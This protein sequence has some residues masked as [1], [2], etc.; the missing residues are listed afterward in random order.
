MLSPAYLD[1]ILA[2]S[3]NHNF[4]IFSRSSVLALTQGHL[5]SLTLFTHGYME[6]GLDHISLSL[7]HFR[8]LQK[9][10]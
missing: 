8:L 4:V 3:L 7:P 5:S 9:I 1:R 10:K 2:L 6:S